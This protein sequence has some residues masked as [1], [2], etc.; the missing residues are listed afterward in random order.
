[1][2]Y[3]AIAAG[4]S[5]LLG[6]VQA[7][8]GGGK[9]HRATEA[10]QNLQTP[11]VQPSKAINDYY[12]E[13]LSRYGASPYQSRLYQMQKQN[14]E[15]NQATSLN[16]ATDRRGG[17]ASVG[18]INAQTNNALQGAGVAAENQNAQRFGQLGQ[19]AGQKN[20]NDQYVFGINSMLPYQKQAQ[21]YSMK[22]AAGG[23]L[24]NAG[25][26]NISGAATSFGEAEL[27]KQMYPSNTGTDKDAAYNNF[28]NLKTPN[29]SMGIQ[30]TVNTTG[31]FNNKLS[32]PQ[33]GYTGLFN[34]YPKDG[35]PLFIDASQNY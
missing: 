9:Q 28:M 5:A 34:R 20:A 15:N 23:Q 16:A 7:L 27:A 22:A 11:K 2:S 4:G 31:G 19:A 14:I 32:N 26:Q 13:A 33:Q 21:L 18:A 8:I 12:Q 35:E 30:Q 24:L 17:L 1:M 10:L 29:P 6:G 3:V 25:L